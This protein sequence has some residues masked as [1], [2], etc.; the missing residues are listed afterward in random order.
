[1]LQDTD[2]YLK[3]VR[4]L[5]TSEHH[6]LDAATKAG[7][8]S[9]RII[10]NQLLLLVVL[11]I[12]VMTN[13]PTTTTTDIAIVIPTDDECTNMTNTG[14]TALSSMYAW[15]AYTNIDHFTS[16]VKCLETAS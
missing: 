9:R 15:I 6:T 13:S 14:Y 11:T 4:V 12:S 10:C 3:K 8:N 1:M 16:I 2:N 5:I 7:D